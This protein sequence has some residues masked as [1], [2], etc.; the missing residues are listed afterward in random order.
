MTQREHLQK[1]FTKLLESEIEIL[2]FQKSISKSQKDKDGLNKMINHGRK[3]IKTICDLKHTEILVSLYNSFVNGKEPF[4]VSLERVI[5]A[6]ITQKWD[7]TDKGF[8]EFLLAEEEARSKSKKEAEE[9]VKQK[10]FIA[11][12]R[13]NGKKVE[14]IYKDGKLKPVIVEDSEA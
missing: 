14:M 10:E 2:Q 4:F 11:N 12:A 8:K 1:I 13:E 3:A 6:K 5:N 9:K 7:K